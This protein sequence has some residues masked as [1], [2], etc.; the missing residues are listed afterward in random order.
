[1]HHRE[2]DHAEDRD[3]ASRERSR[4]ETGE[5]GQPQADEGRCKDYRRQRWQLHRGQIGPW[6]PQSAGDVHDATG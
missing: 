2:T 3:E 5:L 4:D 1:M 6:A